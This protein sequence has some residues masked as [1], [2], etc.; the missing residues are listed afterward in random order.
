SG[1]LLSEYGIAVHKHLED[2][3]GH[4]W[5]DLT[6]SPPQAIHCA[7][8]EGGAWRCHNIHAWG[9][10][11]VTG[12]RTCPGCGLGQQAGAKIMDWTFTTTDRGKDGFGCTVKKES[13][14]QHLASHLSVEAVNTAQGAQSAYARPPAQ[15]VQLR[16]DV[17]LGQR[18]VLR[19]RPLQVSVHGMDAGPN[20]A[21]DDAYVNQKVK[22][23]HGKYE[24]VAVTSATKRLCQSC[25]PSQNAPQSASLSRAE[26][27]TPA[28]NRQLATGTLPSSYSMPAHHHVEDFR[29][30]DWHDDNLPPPNHIEIDNTQDRGAWKRSAKHV[31]GD[32]WMTSSRT[33]CAGCGAA[34]SNIERE[35][36]AGW[37]LAFDRYD[38]DMRGY[39]IFR[40]QSSTSQ[41]SNGTSK[42]K[43]VVT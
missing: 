34:R 10:Y 31:H 35:K 41:Q 5:K 30:R 15:T 14:N 11:F 32:Y 27:L 18:R 4:N 36:I 13:Q 16:E 2:Y 38:I 12:R 43:I 19:K 33:S 29:G 8:S 26:V 21:S 17:D 39:V 1:T 25:D 24:I 7:D 28:F 9:D 37:N 20:D 22:L 40:K 23:E 42:R 3:P 6:L